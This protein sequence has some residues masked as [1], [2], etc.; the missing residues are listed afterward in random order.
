MDRIIPTPNTEEGEVNDNEMDVEK[1]VP[2]VTEQSLLMEE[3]VFLMATS[4]IQ[5]I[6]QMNEIYGKLYPKH[7]VH[8]FSGLA[9]TKT[10]Q[11]L[12][13]NIITCTITLQHFSSSLLVE[14]DFLLFRSQHVCVSILKLVS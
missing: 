9:G 11:V 13:L 6:P 10:K 5:N 8:Q 7:L 4:V 12:Q 3:L 2:S 14:V 1:F